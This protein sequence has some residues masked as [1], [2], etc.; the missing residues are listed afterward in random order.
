MEAFLKTVDK[1]VREKFRPIRDSINLSDYNKFD[2]QTG[3]LL[4]I[5]IIRIDK[6]LNEPV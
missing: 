3:S 1:F 5:L 2:M 6:F 4:E